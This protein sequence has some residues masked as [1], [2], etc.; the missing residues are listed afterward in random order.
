MPSASA[1]TLGGN[2][3]SDEAAVGGGGG[4]GIER[5]PARAFIEPGTKVHAGDPSRSVCSGSVSWSLAEACDHPPPDLIV[6]DLSQ[7]VRV[8]VQSHRESVTNL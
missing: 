6:G 2:G 1:A 3:D 8:H 4:G 7:T 5:G